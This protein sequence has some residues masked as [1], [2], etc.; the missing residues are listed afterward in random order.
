MKKLSLSLAN[1]ITIARFFL[2]PVFILLLLY[3]DKSVL[4]G[5]DNDLLRVFASLIF[6]ATFLSDALDGYIART[7]NQITRLGTIL[8]PL[9]D[10]ALLLSALILISYSSDDAYQ[11]HLPIWFLWL[12]I[13]RDIMLVAG[14]LLIQFISGIVTVRPRIFGKATTFFQAVLILWALLNLPRQPY[15]YFLWTATVFTVVSGVQYFFDG[16][17]QFEKT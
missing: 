3:Y 4:R 7:R 1:R 10:K 9:T 15:V 11:I 12:V 13:C 6:I 8:D 5:E 16:I 14:A 2:I 17:K